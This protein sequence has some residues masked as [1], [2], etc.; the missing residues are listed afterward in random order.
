MYRMLNEKQ[1]AP[2]PHIHK[3]IERHLQKKEKSRKEWELEQDVIDILHAH[4]WN[5][6]A[7]ERALQRRVHAAKAICRH[8]SRRSA[9]AACGRRMD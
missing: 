5:K 6:R 8:M 1:R 2:L 3:K 7:Y 4:G 9:Y